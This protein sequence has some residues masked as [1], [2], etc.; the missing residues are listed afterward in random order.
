MQTTH[1]TSGVVGHPQPKRPFSILHFRGCFRSFQ[2]HRSSQGEASLIKRK[3]TTF[4]FPQLLLGFLSICT[5]IHSFHGREGETEARGQQPRVERRA[6][7]PEHHSR[8]FHP[9]PGNLDPISG[10]GRVLGP[11]CAPV[12]SS[13]D[14]NTGLSCSMVHIPAQRGC[15][16]RGRTFGNIR[17]TGAMGHRERSSLCFPELIIGNTGNQFFRI[18]E[19]QTRWKLILKRLL[20]TRRRS[21]ASQQ[22]WN[23][24]PTL[25]K[26]KPTETS[27]MTLRSR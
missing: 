25:F 3:K 27:K 24:F 5:N 15:Q 23:V 13:G 16:R 7:A 9:S 10:F 12:S 21:L 26:P 18:L 14:R 6:A 2:S 11:G 22:G 19:L 8:Q 1:R 17:G 20:G 4:F